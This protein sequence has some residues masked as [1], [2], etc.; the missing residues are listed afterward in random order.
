MKRERIEELLKGVDPDCI[1]AFAELNAAR[2]QLLAKALREAEKGM[3]LLVETILR[4]QNKPVSD[5][6]VN[7]YIKA[8]PRARA[9]LKEVGLE[10]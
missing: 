7:N 6:I 8:Q 4:L 10:G 3:Q 1:D 9:A 5:E 2:V